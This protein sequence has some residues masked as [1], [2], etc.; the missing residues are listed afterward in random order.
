MTGK[1]PE[2]WLQYADDDL[3]SA[4]VL[5]SEGVCNTAFFQAQLTTADGLKIELRKGILLHGMRP[6]SASVCVRPVLSAVNEILMEA[7]YAHNR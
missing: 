5:L 2:L 6:N 4:K 7:C 3:K 1:L